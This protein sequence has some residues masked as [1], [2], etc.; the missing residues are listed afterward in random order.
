MDSLT[1]YRN[2]IQKTIENYYNQ[3]QSSNADKEN[4]PTDYLILDPKRD[5]YLWIRSGWDGKKRIQYVIL[6]LR[7]ENGKI[8]V[9]T[10]NTNFGIVDDLLA[11]EIPQADIVL[12]FHHP[13]KRPLTEFAVGV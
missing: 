2:T 6:F 7:L 12:A 1:Y 13:Q 11:A 4:T 5:Q 3:S 9:E 10:D 8:W